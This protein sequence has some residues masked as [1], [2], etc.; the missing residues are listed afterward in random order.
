MSAKTV[1]QGFVGGLVIWA[2]MAAGIAPAAGTGTADPVA[3]VT[4]VRGTAET[5]SE[6]P[7]VSVAVL[8]EF[9][10]GARAK[11][12]AGAKLVVLYLESGDQYELGG[13]A[14]VRFGSDAPESIDGAPPVKRRP[15][16][17]KDGAPIKIRPVGLTQAPI[18]LRSA[19]GKPIPALSLAGTVTLERP[20]VFRW[21]AVE[22]GLE[23]QF[24]LKDSS[25]S[26]LFSR[27]VK[28]DFLEL[29]EQVGLHEG[30]SYTW[31]IGTRSGMGQNYLSEYSF[32]A[33]DEATRV[34]VENYRPAADAV[35][36]ERVAFAVWL[37][38]TGLR[39][40]ATAQ[41][42]SIADSGGHVP[43]GRLVPA[44]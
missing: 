4:D 17:G 22:R 41:W 42:K 32:R 19:Q 28:G 29:P 33:A 26:T 8:T 6:K 35:V 25:G 10:P 16:T 37:D 14:L 40:A 30:E 18:V 44:Q 36:A 15:M 2:A 24:V 27:M 12:R 7:D 21:K 34:A 1:K 23:Y 43:E 11:L 31:S 20:P 5:D 39:D 13:P 9:L 3:I 38:Q